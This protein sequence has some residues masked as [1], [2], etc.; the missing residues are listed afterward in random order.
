MTRALL[1]VLLLL[2]GLLTGCVGM[3]EAGP[4]RTEPADDL[5]DAEADAV[6]SGEGEVALSMTESILGSFG[7]TSEQ[8]E[9]E[10]ERIRRE[11]FATRAAANG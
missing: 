10:S 8:I 7:A 1:V 9:R 3:P 11:L 5:L 2:A 6:F 4:V